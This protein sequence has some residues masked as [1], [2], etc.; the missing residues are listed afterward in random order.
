VNAVLVTGCSSGIRRATALHLAQ[1]GF[2]VFATVRK[3]ADADT[4]RQLELP[5]LI[6]ICP[7]DLARL[8]Q[9]RAA[10]EEVSA[11]LDRRGI[12]G[13]YALVN[14]AGAGSV[15]PVELMDLQ[16]FQTELQARLVGPAALVQGF[17]P[18]IRKHRPGV[19]PGAHGRIAWIV[20]PSLTPTRYVASIHAPDFAVNCLVRTLNL[21]LAPWGIPNI[22]IRCGGI[23]TAASARSAWELEQACR[24]WPPERYALY[25]E[26]LRREQEFF[27]RF[28]AKRTPP[29]A[30][31]RVVYR[32]LTDPKPRSR[33]RVGYM[34][35]A[36]ALLESL[37][38]PLADWLMARRG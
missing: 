23:Q 28:D 20:T 13:L 32:A 27:T 7:L 29:E 2:T 16:K 17:L 1:K 11:E 14:N 30:V 15:A 36:A 3:N 21:E 25:A 19:L 18:M 6:P 4:L 8:D 5:D 9:V 26:A 22:M 10:Q 24:E 34:S 12:A 35:G 31:A 33:Y 37:P 38:Q